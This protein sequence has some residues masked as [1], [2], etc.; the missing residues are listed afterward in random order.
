MFALGSLFTYI[1]GYL[2]LSW[3]TVAWLQLLPCLLL[4]LSA[5]AVPDSPYWL[6]ERGREDDARL[7][8]RILRGPSYDLEPELREI[9]EKKRAN[10]EVGR[11]VVSTLA[12]RVFLL[13]FIR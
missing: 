7:S 13:P 6:V 2:L 3:R 5:L 1:S 4:G 9:I 8:L 12:S 10:E 11:G